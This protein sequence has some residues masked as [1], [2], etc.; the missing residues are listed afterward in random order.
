MI[1]DHKECDSVNLVVR[2]RHG[3]RASR[4]AVSH[5]RSN[6][7]QVRSSSGNTGLTEYELTGDKARRIVKR[8]EF[9]H[10]PK[11]ASWLNMAEIEFSVL[12][13]NRLRGR[14]GDEVAPAEPSTRMGSGGT[15]PLMRTQFVIASA[16]RRGDLVAV[17]AFLVPTRLPRSARNDSSSETGYA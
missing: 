7:G 13:R 3:C 11:H 17:A 4:T 5:H 9:N 8:L 2:Q 16:Q 6:F 12:T 14:R 15:P 10:T 1:N